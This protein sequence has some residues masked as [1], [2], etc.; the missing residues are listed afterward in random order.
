[1]GI[2][3]PGE[4]KGAKRGGDRGGKGGGRGVWKGGPKRP[5]GNIG[6]AYVLV[7]EQEQPEYVRIDTVV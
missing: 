6:V 4:P 3:A 7:W 5:R 2:A 1:M